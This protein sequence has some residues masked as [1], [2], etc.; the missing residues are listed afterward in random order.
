MPCYNLSFERSFKLLFEL[1]R[2]RG[3][4]LASRIKAPGSS[5]GV[6]KESE[7]AI[8]IFSSFASFRNDSLKVLY[9]EEAFCNFIDW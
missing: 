5:F 6:R 7:F 4:V 3:D 1:G 9:L 2:L 8:W